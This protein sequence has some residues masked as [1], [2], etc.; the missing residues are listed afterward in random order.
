[1]SADD[2]FEVVRIRTADA[3]AVYGLVSLLH[4]ELTQAGW[5]AFVRENSR[6]GAR[7]MG[8]FGLLDSRRVPH[9]CF[10]F[11]VRQ[12]L[13]GETVLEISELAMLRLPGTS[14]VDALLRFANRLALDLDLPRIAIALER[15]AAWPQDHDALQRSGFELDRVMMLGRAR[16]DPSAHLCPAAEQ[17]GAGQ[18]SIARN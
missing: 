6:D 15:S 1:M 13:A 12:P 18:A 5:R 9:A 8:I 10:A 17:G 7:P 4:P 16:I 3:D 14:L 2:L 11:R